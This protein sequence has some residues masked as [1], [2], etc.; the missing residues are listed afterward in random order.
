M[1][2]YT[3]QER[4]EIERMCKAGANTRT[5]SLALGRTIA[6]V[7]NEIARNGGVNSYDAKAV[8]AKA[9]TSKQRQIE[10][11]K[12]WHREH[13]PSL[14]TPEMK[15]KRKKRLSERL[16][17]VERQLEILFKLIKDKNGIND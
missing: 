12:R 5:I 4:D 15:L 3:D 6:S 16:D 11:T 7:K 17:I 13:N 9:S 14:I 10:A 1:K 8:Q 2:V